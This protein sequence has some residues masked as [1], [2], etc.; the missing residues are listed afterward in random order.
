[1]VFLVVAATRFATTVYYIEDIDSLRFALSATEFDV[2]NN[3]PHFP[4]YPVFVAL[5]QCVHAMFNSVAL[6]F[7]LLGAVATTGIAFALI[8]LVRLN[9]LKI[10]RIVILI[11]LIFNPL[12][13]VMGNRYMP[14]LMGLCVLHWCL[15]F[16]LKSLEERDDSAVKWPLIL[17]LAS[18][19]LCGIRLSYLPFLIPGIVLLAHPRRF[20]LAVLSFVTMSSLWLGL[21]IEDVGLSE[22]IQMAGRDARGHFTQWGGTVYS[23]EVTLLGRLAGAFESL[24]AHGLGIWMPGR[25]ASIVINS[26]V[27]SVLFS[28]GGWSFWQERKRKVSSALLIWLTCCMCYA[29]W[30][31]FFQNITYK[32]RHVL[33]LLTPMMF[34]LASGVEHIRQRGQGLWGSRWTEVILMAYVFCGIQ[35][36][37]QHIQPAAIDQLRDR[38]VASP[39][40]AIVHCP[41]GLIRYYLKESTPHRTF[42]FAKNAGELK[43]VLLADKEVSILSMTRLS[44]L[45]DYDLQTHSFH[46]NPY[47]NRLWSTLV[48]FEYNSPPTSLE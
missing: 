1:M 44:H 39:P 11:L 42:R 10:N 33:P 47:V 30:A 20:F 25:S 16:L 19:I 9:K 32:P 46:H 24:F 40:N 21:W 7:S 3:K 34:V 45:E 31:F 13:W 37:V 48:L 8:E 29:F 23:T 12:I 35:I 4:G 36:G 41:D 5:L 43:Q 14:D 17:G 28:V 38:I 6:S 2:I 26:V 22:F 27:L 15:V 18:S